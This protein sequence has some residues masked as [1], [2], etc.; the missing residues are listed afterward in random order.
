MAHSVSKPC[1][2]SHNDK[3]LSLKWN[4]ACFSNVESAAGTCIQ[5]LCL[6]ILA[7]VS[8]KVDSQSREEGKTLFRHFEKYNSSHRNSD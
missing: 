6:A 2:V 7:I 4:L 3:C 1:F 8:H 5:S